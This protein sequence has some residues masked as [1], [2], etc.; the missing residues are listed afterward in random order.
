MD[1]AAGALGMGG[2]SHFVGAGLL[3]F[4]AELPF[5]IPF[6][7]PSFDEKD[8]PRDDSEPGDEF[9]SLSLRAYWGFGELY[10]ELAGLLP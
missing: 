3:L 2:L 6:N 9:I 5:D 8:S 10:G 1:V 4:G 7:R